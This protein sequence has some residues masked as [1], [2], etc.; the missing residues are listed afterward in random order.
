[1]GTL[2][3][4]VKVET[5]F[6]NFLQASRTRNL[7]GRMNVVLKYLINNKIGT[8]MMCPS[9]LSSTQKFIFFNFYHY[10]KIIIMPNSLEWK[11]PYKRDFFIFQFI[12]VAPTTTIVPDTVGT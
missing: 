12:A 1:M 7:L 6:K 4:Y 8:S 10:L 2:M 5:I 9:I 11:L 3:F